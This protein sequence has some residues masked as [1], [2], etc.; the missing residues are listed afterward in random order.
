MATED[1]KWAT[2]AARPLLF[3]PMRGTTLPMKTAEA[4]PP[5]GTTGTATFPLYARNPPTMSDFFYSVL[6]EHPTLISIYQQVS[7]TV[8]ATWTQA[9]DDGGLA[10]HNERWLN[11]RLVQGK[12][13]WGPGMSMEQL[14]T[15]A[16]ALNCGIGLRLHTVATRQ[17]SMYTIA[18]MLEEAEA[19]VLG[20]EKTL[21]KAIEKYTINIQQIRNKLTET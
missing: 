21:P 10:E 4:T 9:E 6:A 17:V 15:W 20:D 12:P 8:L 19:L 18:P 16:E 3:T 11:W 5:P 7:S 1:L 2:R 13:M 14:T